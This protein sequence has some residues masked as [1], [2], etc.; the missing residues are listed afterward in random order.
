MSKLKYF[1]F[2]VE[3][4]RTEMIASIDEDQIT[5]VISYFNGFRND[6]SHDF[7]ERKKAGYEKKLLKHHEFSIA[8]VLIP[9]LVRIGKD[10]DKIEPH[11]LLTII[12]YRTKIKEKKQDNIMDEDR[13]NES[14]V[15]G[16]IEN[17]YVENLIQTEVDNHEEELKTANIVSPIDS[18]QEISIEKSDEIVI[19]PEF[20]FFSKAKHCFHPSYPAVFVFRDKTFIS[21]NQFIAYSKAIIAKD[22]VAAFKI[23]DYNTSNTTA[24]GLINGSTNGQEIVKE[25]VLYNKWKQLDHN[26]NEIN[27]EIN[28]NLMEWEEKRMGV[29][30]VATREKCNQNDDIKKTLVDTKEQKIVFAIQNSIL[31]SGIK[32]EDI[33]QGSKWCGVNELG[34][35]LD[36]LK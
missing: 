27:K 6:S 24:I 23:M 31:G 28:D 20:Y 18:K 35:L 32:E 7:E 13:K 8:D 4:S 22:D 36:G 19:L 34:K 15:M 29:M 3:G 11:D 30:T 17:N 26:I 14:E 5:T 9:H 10:I 1:H 12:E 33:K 16:Q 21:V 25:N 2:T